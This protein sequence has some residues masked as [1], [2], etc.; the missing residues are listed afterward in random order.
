MWIIKNSYGNPLTNLT[1]PIPAHGDNG[2]ACLTMMRAGGEGCVM[3]VI[4]KNYLKIMSSA[5]YD[6]INGSG[7]TLQFVIYGFRRLS[8][9]IE[10]K[11]V[12]LVTKR[13]S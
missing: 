4:V 2:M 6:T 9:L 11:T 1:K 8:A 7:A 10:N 13:S 3:Y 12:E 5:Q